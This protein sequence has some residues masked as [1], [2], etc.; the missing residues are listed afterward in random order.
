MRMKKI[1]CLFFVVAVTLC[2]FSFTGY[3]ENYQ[4]V[5]DDADFFTDEQIE[6]IEAYANKKFADIDGR[7]YIITNTDKNN[8]KYW[9]DIYSAYPNLA[10]NAVVLVIIRSVMKEYSMFTSGDFDRTIKD[11]EVDDILDDPDIYDSLK[12][13]SDYE[14]AALRFIELAA[15]KCQP[16]I[17]LAAIIGIIFGLIAAAGTAALIVYKYK[18][19]LQSEKYPL[20]RYAS[21][22]LTDQD[23]VFAGTFVTRKVINTGRNGSGGGSFNGGGGARGSR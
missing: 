13:H 6:T 23:D 18:K 20:N 2:T 12:Y 1:I 3:A 7:V 14:K 22:E 10:E 21:L 16:K 5:Y 8:F 4:A 11:G 15:E 19:K 9:N 17:L